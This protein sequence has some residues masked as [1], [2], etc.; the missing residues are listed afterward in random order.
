MCDRFAGLVLDCFRLPERGDSRCFAAVGARPSPVVSALAEAGDGD[1]AEPVHQH[2]IPQEPAC[3]WGDCRFYAAAFL[4]LVCACLVAGV[5]LLTLRRQVARRNQA[6]RESEERLGML[7]EMSFSGVAIHRNGVLLEAND[8]YFAMFGYTPEELLG[9]DVIPLTVAPEHLQRHQQ[10]NYF[11]RPDPFE[12]VGRRRDGTTFPIEIRSRRV[13]Y[14]GEAVVGAVVSDISE[15]KRQEEERALLQQRLQSLWN[16]ASMTEAG[17]EELSDLILAEILSLTKSQY[18]FFGFMDETGQALQVRSWSPEAMAECSVRD[19]SRRFPLDAGGVWV[20]AALSRKPLILNDYRS[21]HPRKR[22][23]PEGH[24]P[25]ERLLV[26]P[27]IREGRV[28]AIAAV[29]NKEAGYTEDDV[30]QVE[31]F[32]ASVMLLVD[33]RRIIEELRENERRMTMAFD[34]A[35]DAVWDLRFGTGE[36][37]LSPRGYTMLGYEPGEFEYTLE[38]WLERVHPDDVGRVVGL[39]QR[40]WGAGGHYHAEYRMLTRDGGWCWVLSRGEVVERDYAGNPLRMLG[41]NVDISEKKRLEERLRRRESD[42]KKSQDI[43][44]LGSW[45]LDL[46]SGTMVWTESLRRMYGLSP[47]DAPLPYTELGRLFSAGSAERL[48]ASLDRAIVTGQ[49]YELELRMVRPGGSEGWMWVRG[50]AEHNSSGEIVGLWGSFQDITARKA[51]ELARKRKDETYQKILDGLNAGVLVYGADTMHM[52]VNPA[53]CAMLGCSVG[54]LL[55]QKVV[56]ETLWTPLREDGGRMPLEEMPLLRVLATGE[57]VHNVVMGVCR[58][59]EDFPV[60]SLVNAFPVFGEEG[61]EQV[62]VSVVDIT[63]LKRASEAL[64]ESEIRYKVLHE[65]SRG[66]IGVHD[67]GLILH[68]NQ[69]LCDITGYT[70]DEL[71]GTDGLQLIAGCSREEVAARVRAGYEGAYE[72]F[73]LRKDGSEYPLRLEARNI[74]YKGRMVRA[75]EFRDITERRRTER[76]LIS[77]RDAAEAASRAKSEF[78]AN[79]SHEIRTPLNGLMGM[80]QLLEASASDPEQARIIEMALFS[81]ERLTR[82]LTDILD[83]SAIEAGKLALSQ[84][85]VDVSELAE[86]VSSLLGVATRRK[87]VCLTAVVAPDVPRRVA[88]DEVRLRQI[89]FNLVGNGLKFTERGTVSLE[90]HALPCGN[91]RGGLLF[92]VSDTGPGLRDD[93]LKTAFEMFGQVAQGMTKAHQGAGLGLPIVKRIV[94]LMGGTLCVDSR[95]GRGTCVYVSL[96]L[97]AAAEISETRQAEAGQT[98]SAPAGAGNLLLV[99]DE[100]A[101]A[102]ALSRLL[103]RKGYGVVVAGDGAQA[104]RELERGDYR[105]VLMDVQMPVMDGVEATRRIRAGEAGERNR[106]VPIIALTAYAMRGDEERFREAGMDAYTAK[107][108]KMETLLDLLDGILDR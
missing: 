95:P 60:W 15:R 75:V 31:A 83:I 90:V 53:A 99:E 80:L 54:D 81:G 47:D 107:P 42:L 82:L 44:R 26:V 13:S 72:I 100:P 5:W 40:N 34:A 8:Q 51:L 103:G 10:R 27:C 25:I 101:G 70:L 105:A 78:L 33:R 91:S 58:A 86:S 7:A 55:G 57:P 69:G 62:I 11:D 71:V 84:G 16:V 63:D 36:A 38:N 87:E 88:G 37:Y 35:S 106:E 19:E 98:A 22:G 96:P 18:S 52:F 67:E 20:E 92:I 3:L 39:V 68:C 65:A 30:R 12:S 23:L 85:V 41:T 74:P 2:W 59:G 66:G 50:E 4:T 49:P 73:G 76:A 108:V 24:V 48:A 64:R 61:V 9:R 43:A 1:A 45:H 93:Q 29:A 97:R 56:D 79:M 17:M 21:G 32:V 46:G 104:L 77:A 94:G 28:F 14:R 102:F 89:L 6:L